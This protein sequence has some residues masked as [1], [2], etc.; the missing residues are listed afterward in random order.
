MAI[1]K[2]RRE[3]L[4][5]SRDNHFCAW[6][7]FW[8]AQS[9]GI[10]LILSTL[11]HRPL[12]HTAVGCLYTAVGCLYL[13]HIL[14]GI[15]IVSL[16]VVIVAC[17]YCFTDIFNEIRS[18]LAL[19]RFALLF[20]L[21][22][23]LIFIYFAIAHRITPDLASL[24]IGAIF[25]AV[26]W[27]VIL[28]GGA[29]GALVIIILSS[30][31]GLGLIIILFKSDTT[32]SSRLLTGVGGWFLIGLSLTFITLVGWHSITFREFA[33]SV[34]RI[35]G[36]FV[37]IGRS[38]IF[39]F[40]LLLAVVGW[41][42]LWVSRLRSSE[43]IKPAEASALASIEVA[44][45]RATAASSQITAEA[46]KSKAALVI[47]QAQVTA[48]HA[49]ADRAAALELTKAAATAAAPIVKATMELPIQQAE[50]KI[51]FAAT[52]QAAALELTKAAATAAAPIVKATMELPIQQAQITATRAAADQAALEL[53]K[54]AATAAV[55]IVT[56]TMELPIREAEISAT[57]K[58]V[59]IRTTAG[60]PIVALGTLQATSEPA[61][62]STD[63]LTQIR[64]H[65]RYI[66]SNN[67][68]RNI[69]LITLALWLAIFI[70]RLRKRPVIDKFED[71]MG[72]SNSKPVEGAGS[73]LRSELARLGRLF[74][75]IDEAR[76]QP[77]TGPLQP[78]DIAPAAFTA[79]SLVKEALGE[80]SK[81][82]IGTLSI[83]IGK[84]ASLIARLVQGR[85]LT[86]SVHK[87]DQR[88][89]MITAGGSGRVDYNWRVEYP[90][91]KTDS[92]I[93]SAIQA[94][95]SEMAIRI[96]TDL[97][98][99]SIGTPKW[100]A[101]QEY[102]EGLRKLRYALRKSDNDK[103]WYRQA[104]QHFTKAI[105]LDQEFGYAHFNLGVVYRKLGDQRA[106]ERAFA[107]AVH[108][109]PSNI[110][111]AYALALTHYELE[112]YE[113]CEVWCT[114]AINRKPT[115]AKV[116]LLRGLARHM[117]ANRKNVDEHRY[118]RDPRPESIRD[119][120]MATALSWQSLCWATATARPNKEVQMRRVEASECTR[121]LAT[122]RF[123]EEDEKLR[124]PQP[125]SS[126]N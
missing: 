49:A 16:L 92:N 11:I 51:T 14:I 53:T 112:Q 26:A 119:F 23:L 84:V 43:E 13:G 22:V 3:S 96:F 25:L 108:S 10:G 6:S 42:Y 41:I 29:R 72:E 123:F 63:A 73:I 56:A 66:G 95:S 77:V 39:R 91:E 70:W 20:L 113:V 4:E 120:Q 110:E 48:T 18:S 121:D 19:R 82:E 61:A 24:A 101:A 85:R 114:A 37:R 109:E 105:A 125:G 34:S 65:L 67:R 98:S 32:S 69:L 117:I 2:L 9:I 93:T 46:T 74:H 103:E 106:A 47:Q 107:R 71:Y 12:L 30:L 97:L 54:A 55:P 68:W 38:N 5:L 102:S 28:V 86:G 62:D 87:D 1:A 52:N 31:A 89:V 99:D 7:L 111:F 104:I 58:S 126:Q 33:L 57:A 21:L 81:V 116:W 50:I 78:L 35:V 124:T 90:K 36:Q 118:P 80:D 40:L 76:P 83:P 100:N 60:L 45:A 44:K 64:D 17:I 79:E 88:F 8:L 15:F 122:A 59:E 115:V 94:M 75:D 27:L